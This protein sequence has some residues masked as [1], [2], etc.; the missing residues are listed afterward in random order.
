MRWTALFQSARRRPAGTVGL[1]ACAVLALA[2]CQTYQELRNP[3]PPPP[4]DAGELAAGGGQAAC[5]N[6][7]NTWVGRMTALPNNAGNGGAGTGQSMVSC[8]PT[9]QACHSWLTD[10]SGSAKGIIVEDRCSLRSSS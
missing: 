2:G 1:V 7:Q 5:S 10:A 9:R 8:F 4:F 3:F 6:P